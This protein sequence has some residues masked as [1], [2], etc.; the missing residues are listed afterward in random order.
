MNRTRRDFLTPGLRLVLLLPAAPMLGLVFI[1][2]LTDDGVGPVAMVT[3]GVL[4]V[5]L[6]VVEQLMHAHITVRSDSVRMG[7]WPMFRRTIP[8]RE[9]ASVDAVKID[10]MRDYG[11]WGIKGTSRSEKG[12]LFST[13]GHHGVMIL[14][15]DG[16]RYVVTAREPMDDLVETLRGLTGAG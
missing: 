13:G 15:R 2:M 5:A 7:F 9:I 16:R 8:F 3:A 14:T 4:M 1:F 10:P 6:I 11:G 12:M